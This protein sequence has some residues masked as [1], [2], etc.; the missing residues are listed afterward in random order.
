MTLALRAQDNKDEVQ[1][2]QSLYG[3]GKQQVVSEHMKIPISQFQQFWALYDA[4]E[5]TRKE[6]GKRRLLNIDEYAKNYNNLTDEQAKNFLMNSI[7]IR[8]DYLKLQ[9][10]TFAKMAKVITPV[11]AAQFAQLEMYLETIVRMKIS[12]EIPL[13]GEFET[14][15]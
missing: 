1:L 9:R 12:S 4:Y 7:S 6:I 13:I 5:I 11:K 10:E 2:I 14:K 15:K 8:E 3:M